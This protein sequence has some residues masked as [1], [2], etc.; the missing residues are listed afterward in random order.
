MK[1]I[2]LS[3]PSHRTVG[4]REVLA[5]IGGLASSLALG[6]LGSSVGLAGCTD[7]AKLAIARS[8]TAC[9]EALTLFTR[10]VDQIRNGMAEGA[11]IL[12]K[13]MPADPKG[14]SL[15]L[16]T[17]IKAARENVKDLSY[18]KSTF[19]SFA[20]LDGLVLRSEIDPDRLVGQNVVSVYPTL[21]KAAEPPPKLVEAW[22]E[23]DALRGVKQGNDIAWIVAHAVVGA[24]GKVLGLFL[25]GFS[26]RL[27]TGFV[28]D[29]VRRRVD[30]KTKDQR[31]KSE[32]YL[33]VVKGKLAYGHPDA[34]EVHAS[35]IEKRDIMSK[36]GGGEY[37]DR[38]ELEG[39]TW[40]IA[41]KKAPMFGDDAAVATISTIY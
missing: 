40:G 1:R 36:I 27:Y 20:Q 15:E 37:S 4:R 32:L 17:A 6:C 2:E 34:P 39:K 41:A 8:S 28:Q 13:R 11:K 35:E 19:F 30:E 12:A 22:G 26:L 3:S 21:A 9:D 7:K 5:G 23:M 14:S 16:Q 24:D 31:E 25:T 38:L 29:E 10:D 33:F 18:A